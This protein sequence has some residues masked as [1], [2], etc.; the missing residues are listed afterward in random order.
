MSRAELAHND[1]LSE[2]LR[3]LLQDPVDGTSAIFIGSDEAAFEGG[4]TYRCVDGVPVLFNEDESLFSSADALSDAPTTQDRAYRTR[5]SLKNF[6]RQRVLP[7]LTSDRGLERR[8]EKLRDFAAGKRVLVIGTGDKAAFYR[9]VFSS[10]LVVTSDVHLQ[11]GADVVCDA[12]NLP[13]QGDTFGLVLAAQ[14]LEHTSRPW[15]VARE[16][17][18]VTRPSGV[19]QVEVPFCFPYHGQPYD[20]YRFSPS[21]LRFLFDEAE[22]SDF[23]VTEGAA[24]AAA[25]FNA[26]LLADRFAS[27]YLRWGA[28]FA[29]RLAFG[30]L[31]YVDLLPTGS[32]SRQVTSAK[33][34]AAT[35]RK[36][37]RRRTDREM[38]D[39]LRALAEER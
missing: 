28:V 8:Y 9:E 10:S 12:H 24:A 34:F 27:R 33:G 18:R 5:S 17:M 32:F 7:S 36:D 16:L 29:G 13:F 25:V 39:E 37:G 26:Q 35:F 4:R 19:I 21:G 3:V 23:E 30:W 38:L 2:K 14:V 11:F 6:V 31:K 22:M 20:F 15:R 1:A